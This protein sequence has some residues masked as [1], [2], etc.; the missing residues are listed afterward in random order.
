VDVVVDATA[1]AIRFATRARKLTS[2]KAATRLS[3]KMAPRRKTTPP[4]VSL[5]NA[6]KAIGEMG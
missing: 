3:G 5:L 6:R 4:I 2:E 1:S